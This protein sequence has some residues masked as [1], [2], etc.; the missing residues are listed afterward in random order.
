LNT[1]AVRLLFEIDDHLPEMAL[2]TPEQTMEEHLCF[3]ATVC[4]PCP[5]GVFIAINDYSLLGRV[6]AWWSNLWK[7]GSKAPLS[8]L[9]FHRQFRETAW[10]LPFEQTI[11]A[12]SWGQETQTVAVGL[13][14]GSVAVL[15]MVDN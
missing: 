5:A 4:A 8:S 1:E 13:G 3:S 9:V 14:N 11:E 6:D 15:K 2:T 7:N 10:S 12:L